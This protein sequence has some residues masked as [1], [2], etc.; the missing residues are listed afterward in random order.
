MPT[1]K[2]ET[3]Q[4]ATLKLLKQVN[5]KGCEPTNKRLD[6]EVSEK[7]LKHSKR[8]RTLSASCATAHGNRLN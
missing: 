4:E 5:Q 2:S 3:I 7:K 6:D 1:R 8:S